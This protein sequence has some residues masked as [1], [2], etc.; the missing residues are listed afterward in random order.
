VLFSTEPMLRTQLV[1]LQLVL[2]RR[3]SPSSCLLVL[4][5]LF[6]EFENESLGGR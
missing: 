2:P 4:T 5:Y 6:N 3:M 1:E